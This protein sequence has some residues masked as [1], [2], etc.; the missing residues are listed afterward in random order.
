VFLNMENMSQF[1]AKDEN[2]QVFTTQ[3]HF[4]SSVLWPNPHIP[5]A[6]REG[7][8]VL[9]RDCLRKERTGASCG[10]NMKA[11]VFLPGSTRKEHALASSPEHSVFLGPSPWRG[12][13]ATLLQPSMR[14]TPE[15]NSNPR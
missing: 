9:L 5:A 3:L 10:S 8:K 12:R 4:L 11:M 13:P 1:Q 15:A 2:K 14:S 6:D 7:P